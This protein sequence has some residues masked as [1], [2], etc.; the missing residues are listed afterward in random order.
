MRLHTM[1]FARLSRLL[2]PMFAVLGVVAALLYAGSTTGWETVNF[3]NYKRSATWW[4]NQGS[5]YLLREWN[6]TD[7][8]IWYKSTYTT[9]SQSSLMSK[10]RMAFAAANGGLYPLITTIPNDYT[11]SWTGSHTGGLPWFFGPYFTI[12]PTETGGTWNYDGVKECYIVQNSRDSQTTWANYANTTYLGEISP[13]GSGT[14]KLYQRAFN[15]FWQLFAVRTEYTDS[16]SVKTRQIIDAWAN[17]SGLFSPST[18][19]IANHEINVETSKNVNGTYTINNLVMPLPWDWVGSPPSAPSGLTATT[20]SSDQIDLAWTDNSSNETGFEIDRA[21]NSGFTSGLVTF[22]T[23]ADTTSYQ[24]TGLSASTT[25]YYRVRATNSYGDSANSNTASATTSGGAQGPYGGIA[26]AIPGIIQAE[27]YDVGGEGVAYHDL[28]AGNAGSQYRTDDVDIKTTADTGAGYAVG[29]FQ[30][31]E[32]LEYTV[33]V[34]TAGTYDIDIRVGSANAGRTMH[35]EFDGVNKTGTVNVP[36]MPD[37][38]QYQTVTV[39]G[40][41]LNAGQ[42][43]MRVVMGSLDYMDLN[44]VEVVSSAVPP[45]APSGLTATAVSPSEIDLAWTDNSTNETGFEFDRALNSS[46]TSG[47]V[48][49][50]TGANQTSYQSTGLSASTTYYYRVRATNAAGDSANSNTASA[51][52]WP[53]PRADYQFVDSGSATAD[54]SGNGNILTFTN[55]AA[56]NSAGRTNGCV[57]LDGTNDYAQAAN[58]T[59]L[60]ITGNQITVAAWVRFDVIDSTPE[61]ILSKPK[62]ATQHQSPY[63]SYSLHRLGNGQLRIWLTIGGVGKSVAGGSVV[64]NTWYHVAGVYNGSQITLYINGAPAGTPLSVTGNITGY[65]TP[66]RLGVNGAIGEALDGR[67]DGVRVYNVALTQ[68]QIQ[69]LYNAGN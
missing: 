35:I 65:S 54:S 58:S 60:N 66:L 56:F 38:D 63:H 25:Y 1:H 69:N 64:A 7:P 20:V 40:V 22:T 47:L 32:W 12:A 46:F 67:V 24:S 21:L 18:W 45:A 39:S 55:G 41:S 27:D 52:T 15:G 13:S 34:A 10:I 42:Q 30:P 3:A 23:G 36:Q 8:F 5:A 33:N 29:W 51:T 2:V 59:S 43:V 14:Y 49:N 62:S 6:D 16:G 57:L 53:S 50:T 48:T 17:L 19:Y 11:V 26:W 31:A 28:T 44:W 4:N 37:W 9:D 61:I 68:T